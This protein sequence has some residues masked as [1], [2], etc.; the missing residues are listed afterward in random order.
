V[1]QALKKSST[2]GKLIF[3]H[4]DYAKTRSLVIVVK[5][6]YRLPTKNFRPQAE[7]FAYFVITLPYRP[8]FGN[9]KIS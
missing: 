5:N 3:L 8:M 2:C 6:I 7:V 4:L 1:G 9:I